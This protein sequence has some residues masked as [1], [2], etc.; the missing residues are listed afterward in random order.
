MIVF[1][2]LSLI[3]LEKIGVTSSV[4]RERLMTIIL[5]LQADVDSEK[6]LEDVRV[7]SLVELILDC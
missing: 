7:Y 3:D 1:V 5:E 6:K 2:G 4:E